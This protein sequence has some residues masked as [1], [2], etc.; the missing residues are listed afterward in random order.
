MA[1][2]AM[3]WAASASHV[4]SWW[5]N[6]NKASLSASVPQNEKV[7]DT[8]KGVYTN[9][10]GKSAYAYEWWVNGDWSAPRNGGCASVDKGMPSEY[11]ASANGGF[12]KGIY[13]TKA[14]PITIASS[15]NNPYAYSE[16]VVKALQDGYALSV[17]VENSGIA[18]AY[19][20]WGAEYEI[21]GNGY[22][23]TSVWLTDS[24]DINNSPR[25]F[26]QGVVCLY[27]E[28]NGGTGSVAFNTNMGPQ[29]MAV[30]GLRVEPVSIPEPATAVLSLSALLGLVSKRRRR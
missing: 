1:D 20:L 2:T 18:H 12:L 14:Y 5:Q 15:S 4:I 21:T 7:F 9:G 16:A 17:S 29:L 30:S 6:H 22:E 25:L 3:C 24:D 23:L 10:G 13:D 28:K 27:S 11:I 8:F 19:T 26:K